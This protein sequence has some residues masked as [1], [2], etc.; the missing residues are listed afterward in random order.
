MYDVNADKLDQERQQLL[1]IDSIALIQ[2]I[3]SS[4]EVLVSLKEEGDESEEPSHM[5]SL[6]GCANLLKS[7][8]LTLYRDESSEAGFHSKI[9][10]VSTPPTVKDNLSKQY[11]EMIVKLESDIRSHIR[12]EQQM[13]IHI[14]NVQD[15][16]ELLEKEKDKHDK[17]FQD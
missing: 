9:S 11:E 6:Q 8:R 1:P 10:T 5:N 17:G 15:K 7:S 14:E 2:Y 12:I 13:R 4:V 3:R 16:V